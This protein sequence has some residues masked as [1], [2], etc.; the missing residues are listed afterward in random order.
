MLEHKA[1]LLFCLPLNIFHDMGSP[2]TLEMN[3]I[4][5]DTLNSLDSLRMCEYRTSAIMNWRKP[6]K[7]NTFR[8]IF[9][10]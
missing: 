9:L 2:H 5:Q 3:G 4:F 7:Q 1:K 6:E 10:I 8:Q